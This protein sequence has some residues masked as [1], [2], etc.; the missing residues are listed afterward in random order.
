[1]VGQAFDVLA[2]PI[3]IAP[4][5]RLHDLAVEAA[6]PVLEQAP[7]GDVV[8]EGMLEGVLD[9][10]EDSRL[11][12]ELGGL[13]PPDR[14]A[15]LGLVPLG[16]RVEQPERDVLPDDRRR[17]ENGPVR[18]RQPVDARGQHRLHRRRHLDR[19]Q[20]SRQPVGAALPDQRP[21]LDERPDALL[22]EERIALCSLDQHALERI[23]SDVGPDQRAEELSG[24][25]VR[26]G[27]EPELR[28]VGA[29]APLVRILRPV[30]H[31]E[32][33]PGRRQALDQRVEQRL[34]LGI[35][36]VEIF[37]DHEQRLHLALSQQ[38]SLQRVQGLPATLG[39]IKRRP[40]G[41][42]GRHVEQRQERRQA[43]LQRAVQS[44]E[45][46]GQL[47]LHRARAV[48]VFDTGR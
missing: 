39:R 37:E 4:L 12:Q 28:V 10:R 22:Q 1:M 27:I 43:A 2:E 32:Q 5:D 17:L 35:D 13:E 46:P 16:N 34:G 42:V 8:C 21:G 25:I 9:V 36:P 48:P 30:V 38:E 31:E 26:Q 19:R 23:E 47:L 44:Q 33:H 18:R 45:L 29:A 40:R 41:V 20:G 15:E 3:G 7:V 24:V 14:G 11:V 6:A